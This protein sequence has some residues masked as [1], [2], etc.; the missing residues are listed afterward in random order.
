M[1]AGDEIDEWRIRASRFT[2]SNREDIDL[3]ILQNIEY[4]NHLNVFILAF[5]AL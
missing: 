3:L 1:Q 5:K 2:N 4:M